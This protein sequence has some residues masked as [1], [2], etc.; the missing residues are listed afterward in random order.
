MSIDLFLF[1]FAGGSKYSYNHFLNE[2]LSKINL[3]PVEYPGRGSRIGE[4]LLSDMHKLVE[5]VYQQIKPQLTQ[6]YAFYG[7]SMGT[8][9]SYLVT[10]KIIREGI[11]EPRHL[12]MTGR[13]G[14]SA[15][16][17]ESFNHLLTREGLKNKLRE[18]GGSSEEV[19]NNEALLDMFE[20]ILKAD[21]KAIETYL[22]QPD[23]PFHIPMT[24][25]SGTE[26]EISPEEA[27]AWKKE[28]TADVNVMQ[29]S[30]KHFFI[31]EHAQQIMQL[32]NKAL[33]SDILIQR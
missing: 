19:L 2:S 24:V 28:T 33:L 27:N 5:D 31:Y 11:A 8:L 23:T 7:H 22:Y 20:P 13:G 21:F 26:E 18:M 6:P 29:L 17:P 15:I 30:G 3:I 14:P 4:P 9:V 32:I 1:P 16:K 10:K 12:I 25:I